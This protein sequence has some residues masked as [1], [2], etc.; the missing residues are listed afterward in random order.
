MGIELK[1]KDKFKIHG[2]MQLT[3]ERADGSIQVVRKDNMI[4]NAGFDFIADSIAR[5]SGR[6]AV[7][8]HIG[9]GE[10]DD[11]TTESQTALIDPLTPRQSATYEHTAG[12]KSF[13]ISATFNPGVCTGAI[14]EAGVFNAL[15]GGTMLDRVVFSVINKGADDTL[16]VVFTFNMS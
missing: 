4:V 16:R 13:T 5:T 2:S 11:G 6:P 14:T 1:S 8:S 10:S 9:V 12:T 3:L 15:T 7:M